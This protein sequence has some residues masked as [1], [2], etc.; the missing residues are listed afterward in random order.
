[1][2]PKATTTNFKKKNLPSFNF[3]CFPHTKYAAKNQKTSKS[4]VS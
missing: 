1:M 2:G 3:F 4:G